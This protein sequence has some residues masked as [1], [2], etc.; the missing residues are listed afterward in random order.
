MYGVVT[1]VLFVMLFIEHGALYSA[2][3]TTET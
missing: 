2:V 1:G 3:K